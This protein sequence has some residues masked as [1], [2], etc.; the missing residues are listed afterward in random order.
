MPMPTAQ[1]TSKASFQKPAN[2][3]SPPKEVVEFLEKPHLTI[4]EDSAD[5]ALKENVA[6]VEPVLET[7]APEEV[8]F[9]N[10]PD[11]SLPASSTIST[12]YPADRDYV[13]STY[14]LPPPSSH[15]TFT[16][17]SPQ[18]IPSGNLEIMAILKG[19]VGDFKFWITFLAVLFV[20][21]ITSLIMFGFVILMRLGLLHFR[22][23]NVRQ[24]VNSIMV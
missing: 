6:Y 16:T 7:Y 11:L 17:A 10:F 22:R 2:A 5:A 12:T 21:G 9:V 24:Q 23:Y 18:V 4:F 1:P 20:L 13:L 3:S 8:G 19:E 14:L 15:S